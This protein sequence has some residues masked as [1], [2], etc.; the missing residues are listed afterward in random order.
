MATT[1]NEFQ[2]KDLADAI[3]KSHWP[4]CD[5]L[6]EELASRGPSAIS[7]LEYAAGSRIHQVRSAA[8]NALNKIS[9]E[10]ATA[11]AEKLIKD[12]AYEVRENA[13][14]VLGVPTPK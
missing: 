9:H 14:K 4:T 10:R 12:K 7:A 13:A 1:K 11:L 8:L 5:R 2:F 3:R 6:A